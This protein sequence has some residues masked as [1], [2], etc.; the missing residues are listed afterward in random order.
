MKGIYC[1]FK[2]DWRGDQS[3]P[4]EYKGVNRGG[5][6]VE[7]F[8][9]ITWFSGGSGRVISH[10]QQSVKG[11]KEGGREVKDFGKIMWFSG[12][13]GGIINNCQ[14]SIKQEHRELSAN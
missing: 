4:T 13:N 14:Q 1:Y 6:E 9:G 3:L 11:N 7:D 5:E 2:G 8:G 12:E 10:C